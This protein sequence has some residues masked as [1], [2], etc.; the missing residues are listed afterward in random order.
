MKEKD[1]IN[2]DITFYGFS[3]HFRNVV[4]VLLVIS[5]GQRNGRFHYKSEKL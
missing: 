1:Y 4:F 5:S 3:L 2:C